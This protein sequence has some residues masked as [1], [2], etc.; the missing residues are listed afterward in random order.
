MRRS[1][2]FP[3]LKAAAILLYLTQVSVGAEQSARPATRIVVTERDAG[4]TVRIVVGDIL[5]V[6]LTS[7]PATGYSWQEAESKSS[8]LQPV[9]KPRYETIPGTALG[10]S[11]DQVF[12]YRAVRAATVRLSFDFVRTWEKSPIRSFMV[13]IAISGRPQREPFRIHGV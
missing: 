6:R 13:T 5:V 4:K 8:G 7:N 11:G 2:Y 3:V 10:A 9:G 12:T 1:L